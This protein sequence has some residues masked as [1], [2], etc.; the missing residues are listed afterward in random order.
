MSNINSTKGPPVNEI[1][2]LVAQRQWLS[3]RSNPDPAKQLPI[4]IRLP[5][6]KERCPYTGLS[7]SG[8]NSLILGPNPPVRSVPSCMKYAKRGARLID[9]LSLL[10][11]LDPLL[12]STDPTG[13][14]QGDLKP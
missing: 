9:L 1:M 10:R 4:Y 5:K 6:N 14:G 8:L 3:A 13:A 11:Y 2:A 12:F 7:R